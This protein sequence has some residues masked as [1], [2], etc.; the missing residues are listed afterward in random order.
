VNGA[1]LERAEAAAF[2]SIAR[3]GGWPTLR[4]GDAVCIA[5]PAA[6]GNTM[7]NRVT[8]LGLDGA[9]SDDA[10]DEIAAFYR[11][12]GTQYAIATSPVAP[13]DLAGRL[14][15]RG[16][17][18]GYGWMKFGRGL[19]EAEDV[20]TNLVVREATDGTEVA[21]IVAAGYGVPGEVAAAFEPLALRDDWHCFVATLDDDPVG[22]GALFVHEGVGWFG[23]A[24][25]LPDKRR[26]GAQNALLAARV[27]RG[28]EASCEALT[29]ETGKRTDDLPSNSY[30]NILRAGFRELYVRPNYL[31]PQ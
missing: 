10:L 22:T 27:A 8:G 16:F 1:Q 20:D 21:A 18:S 29:V 25:T 11:D 28:R 13:R 26:L 9:A 24:A 17:E 3:A 14:K 2:E 7:F 6:P 5:A 15:S 4:I 30:R 23:A 19:E 12:V 31:S